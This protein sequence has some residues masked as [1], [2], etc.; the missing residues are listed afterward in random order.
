MT[1]KEERREGDIAD[2]G[3]GGGGEGGGGRGRVE[4]RREAKRGVCERV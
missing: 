1:I 2:E 3:K 4:A